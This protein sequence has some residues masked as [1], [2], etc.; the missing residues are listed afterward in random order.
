MAADEAGET[1][2]GID[3]QT[4]VEIVKTRLE[5]PK[6]SAESRDV[7]ATLT[8]GA[9]TNGGRSTPPTPRSFRSRVIPW[10]VNGIGHVN[11][12]Y[13]MMNPRGGKNIVTGKPFQDIDQ[14]LSFCNWAE[15]TNNI[16]ELWYCTSMQS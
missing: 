2:L 16:K 3:T 8:V 1:G 9:G 11:L 7:P 4:G 14:L 12:H 6:E 15:S 10:P 5:T 13:S